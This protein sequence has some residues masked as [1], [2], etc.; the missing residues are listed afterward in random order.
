MDGMP[1]RVSV[2]NSTMRMNVFI[3][4]IFR[5]VHCRAHAQR[6]RDEQGEQDNAQRVHDVWKNARWFL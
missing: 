4:G 1:A 2:A 3:G 5:Q 6:Q